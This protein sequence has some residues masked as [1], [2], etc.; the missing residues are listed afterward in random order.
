L[1]DAKWPRRT[2][3]IAD[4]IPQLN[5]NSKQNPPLQ[6]GEVNGKISLFWTFSEMQG[7][8]NNCYG[9]N[10]WCRA[11]FKGLHNSKFC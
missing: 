1:D 6:Y 4:K 7:N 10:L 8:K 9:G 11:A 2:Q 5:K 3:K